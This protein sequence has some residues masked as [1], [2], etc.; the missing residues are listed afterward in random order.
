MASERL[1]VI[2]DLETGKY[3]TEAKRASDSTREIGASAKET[4]SQTSSMGDK[5]KSA[6]VSMLRFGSAGAAIVVGLAKA[7]DAVRDMNVEAEAIENRFDQ[8][9]GAGAEDV[10]QWSDEV[11][12]RFGTSE[13]AVRD[14]ANGVADLLVP[15]GFT[16]TEATGLTQEALTLA[17][18]LSEWSGGQIDVADSTERIRKALLGERESLDEL[19]VKVLQSDVNARLAAAGNDKLTGAEKARA[20]ALATLNIIQDKSTDAITAYEEGTNKALIAQKALQAAEEDRRDLLADALA[21]EVEYLTDVM[22]IQ[23]EV[24]AEAITALQ[25]L[26]DA[27]SDTADETKGVIESLVD[28]GATLDGPE[29]GMVGSLFAAG[30][31]AL[32]LAQDLRELKGAADDAQPSIEGSGSSAGE[33]AAPMDDFGD[34]TGE[35]ADAMRRLADNSAS[36]VDTI[37]A[38]FNPVSAATSAMGRYLD[39]QAKVDA[40]VAEGKVGTREWAEAQVDLA[41]ATAD[42]QIAL[43]DLD[44]VRGPQALSDLLNIP[45]ETAQEI[46]EVLGLIDGTE[47]NAIITFTERVNRSPGQTIRDIEGGDSSTTLPTLRDPLAGIAGA[48]AMGGPVDPLNA[49]TVGENGIEVFVPS[50]SGQIIPNH[51][52]SGIGGGSTVVNLGGITVTGSALSEDPARLARHIRR[53]MDRELAD[54]RGGTV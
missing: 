38:L 1:Q 40:L 8:V 25:D 14:L 13:R 50:V 54:L 34:E 20:E 12:E 36:Y 30:L 42:A 45:L 19:G 22:E 49:Y 2:L 39:A 10:R 3:R 15:L 17:N 48:R 53:E 29:G 32:G 26:Q 23:N 7:I 33:A 31:K 6:Q 51:Q 24:L 11:N 16:R 46:L 9:F 21:P 28:F 5:M 35:A 4:G 18:A 43:D 44:G 27:E 41:D 52:L 47:V 37:N